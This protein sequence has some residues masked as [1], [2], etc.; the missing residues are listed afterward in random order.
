MKIL[1]SSLGILTRDICLNDVGNEH[2]SVFSVRFE[3]AVDYL[4]V[5]RIHSE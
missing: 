2:H 5:N 1:N 4:I 3:S